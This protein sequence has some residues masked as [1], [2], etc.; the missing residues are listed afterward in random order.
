MSRTARIIIILVAVL[1]VAGIVY[2]V[3]QPHEYPRMDAFVVEGN[4]LV[5]TAN[6]LSKV[7]VVAIPT[8]TEITPAQYMLLGTASLEQEDND[9]ERW[10]SPVP[11][12]PVLATEIFAR[13]YDKDNKEVG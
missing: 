12:E 2:A 10:A 1:A 4:D 8:G 9:S 5:L 13:G 11:A 6:A 3:S 7:E